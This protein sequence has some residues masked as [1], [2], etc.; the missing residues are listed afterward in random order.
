MES[1]FSSFPLAKFDEFIKRLQ[2]ETPKLPK[3]EARLAQFI[4]LNISSLGLETG[5]SLAGKAGVSEVTVGRLLRRLGC[6]GMKGLKQLL[7]EH[8]SVT[9]ASFVSDGDIPDRYQQT[10]EAEVQAL[11][12]VFIQTGGRNWET[13]TRLLSGSERIYV[14]GFQSVRGLVED[15][16]RR[17]ALAR[18]D[19]FFLSAH[20]DMLVEWLA[21]DP[22][23]AAKSCLILVDVVPYATET[24]KLARLA[25]EQ[26]RAIIV[27]SDEYCHWS[28]DLADAAIYAPSRTGLYLES[29]IGIVAALSLVVDAAATGNPEESGRRLAEWKA[30][31]KRLGIF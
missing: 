21:P 19:V 24:V 17:L 13:I 1:G 6:D 12:S 23:E 8:Y 11:T 5:K 30:N 4:S 26:G 15:F 2:E 3:Q 20:D 25:K 14:T 27:V 22:Q 29:T 7:R 9:T 28:R 31:S 18:R 10:H 16:H